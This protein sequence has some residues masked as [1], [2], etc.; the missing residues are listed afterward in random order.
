[1]LSGVYTTSHH[2]KWPSSGHQLSVI[3]WQN[4]DPACP[5]SSVSGKRQPMAMQIGVCRSTKFALDI[6]TGSGNLSGVN[7][8]AALIGHCTCAAWKNSACSVGSQPHCAIGLAEVDAPGRDSG[9]VSGAAQVNT[10]RRR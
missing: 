4:A 5:I 9:S 3:Q 10:P 1:M 7:K 6:N 2:S 8:L